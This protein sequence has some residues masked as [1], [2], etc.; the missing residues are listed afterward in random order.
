MWKLNLPIGADLAANDS[1]LIKWIPANIS[2]LT[3][4]TVEWVKDVVNPVRIL[5]ENVLQT[6]RSP[7]DTLTNKTEAYKKLAYYLPATTALAIVTCLDKPLASVE[8]TLEFVNANLERWGEAL[9]WISTK[10]LANLISKNGEAKWAL[11]RWIGSVIEWTWDLITSVVK[12]P[13][14]LAEK[15]LNR[16]RNTW[17]YW[18]QVAFNK[19]SSWVS[20]TQLTPWKDFIPWLA[21]NDSYE[22][23]DAA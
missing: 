1:W 11:P 15:W 3:D 7:I 19:V 22:Q 2:T 4:K 23:K 5:W 17:G 21:A 16:V 9:K 12:S 13:L 14:W 10:F 18:T 20:D 8:K 6:I